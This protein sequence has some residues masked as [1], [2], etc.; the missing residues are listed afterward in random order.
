MIEKQ[1]SL[2]YF[3]SEVDPLG[4]YVAIA[5]GELDLSHEEDVEASLRAA[6]LNYMA[7]EAK[8]RVR[9]APAALASFGSA[10]V[11]GMQ[12]EMY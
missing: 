2:P 6:A 10:I 4:H 9:R 8:A 3:S 7:Q 11:R 12:T 1:T 5:D